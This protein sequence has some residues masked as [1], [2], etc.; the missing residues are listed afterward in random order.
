[1]SNLPTIKN[2]VVFEP[3]TIDELC[4]QL[5]QSAFCPPNF[6]DNPIDVKF[7][8]MW[9]AE[10]GLSQFQSITGVKIIN[11]KPTLYGDIFLAVC[12]KNPQWQDMIE[13]YD[14]KTKTARCEVVRK[15]HT[16]IVS[17]FSMADAQTAKLIRPGPWTNF[18]KR[19]L[20]M[21]A[22]G[23]AL[24]D[25]Y[26]DTLCGMIDDTEAEDYSVIDV[27]PVQMSE[28]KVLYDLILKQEKG[29]LIKEWVTEHDVPKFNDLP[30]EFVIQKLEELNNVI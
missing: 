26:A 6:R 17:L 28:H 5:S 11:G 19:M 15:G 25:A 10:L 23:F 18:P 4:K 21:R 29:E 24:R 12:K 30:L 14:E 2:S 13:T 22:R 9:G 16:P 7:A 8:I 27:T 1:M 20:Q 3:I